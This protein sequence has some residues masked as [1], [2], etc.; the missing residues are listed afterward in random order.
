MCMFIML[1]IFMI[2]TG[3]L[4][5]QPYA[6]T[7]LLHFWFRIGSFFIPFLEPHQTPRHHVIGGTK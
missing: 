7:L 5:L 2:R 1:I 4:F 6:L 3:L